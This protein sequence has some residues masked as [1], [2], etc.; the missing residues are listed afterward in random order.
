[1]AERVELGG[2]VVVNRLHFTTCRNQ[3]S[4]ILSLVDRDSDLGVKVGQRIE[5]RSAR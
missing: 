4:G 5:R 1:M 2:L 3:R